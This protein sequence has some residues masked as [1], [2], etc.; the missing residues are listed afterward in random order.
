MHPIRCERA[1]GS[2]AGGGSAFPSLLG[3]SSM[4]LG[5]WSGT[6]GV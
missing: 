2:E 1:Q 6:H 3:I 4:T 5:P